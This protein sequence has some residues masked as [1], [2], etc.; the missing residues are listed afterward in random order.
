MITAKTRKLLD[1]MCKRTQLSKPI[2]IEKIVVEESQKWDELRS[3]SGPQSF[4]N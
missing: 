2:Q 4:K 1:K 3:L